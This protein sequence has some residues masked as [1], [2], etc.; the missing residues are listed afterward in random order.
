MDVE[1][2]QG[3]VPAFLSDALSVAAGRS[4][5]TDPV[6]ARSG[7]PAGNASLTA[8][9]GLVLLVLSLAELVTLL[10]VGRLISWHVVIGTL[11]IPPALVKTGSTGW[12]VVRYYRGHAAYAAAGPPPLV[13][14]VLGPAVVATTLSLLGSGIVLV[15]LGAQQSRSVLLSAMG[16]RIDWVTVHQAAFVA[17]A[18]VTGLHVLGRFVP[19]LRLTVIRPEGNRQ[20]PGVATRVVLLLATGVVAVVASLVVL[21]ATGSWQSDHGQPAHEGTPSLLP[22]PTGGK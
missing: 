12:R 6:L 21:S 8:W 11:L 16:V 2:L 1:R 15:W 7:G 17:W 5:R 3:Q 14:R 4:H 10:D 20:V 13:L 18:V 22:P 19:A 9:V